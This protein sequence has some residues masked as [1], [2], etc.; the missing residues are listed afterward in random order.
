MREDPWLGRSRVATDLKATAQGI[1]ETL[2]HQGQRGS[3]AR[4]AESPTT[5]RRVNYPHREMFADP[6]VDE[7]SQETLAKQDVQ[8]MEGKPG[9]HFGYQRKPT[10]A[11]SI[12]I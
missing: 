12:N 2:P 8:G 4:G 6:V 3:L 5:F 1:Q 9:N 7:H 10:R 11:Y